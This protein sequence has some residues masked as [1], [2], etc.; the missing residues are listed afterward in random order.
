V[1]AIGIVAVAFVALL[2]LLPTGLGLFR[3]AMNSTVSSQ[4]AQRVLTD[5]QQTDFDIL[6][7]GIARDENTWD[8]FTFRA[9]TRA[10]PA[11]RYFDDQGTEVIPV[12]PA[13]LSATEKRRILYHVNTR[14]SVRA[15]RPKAAVRGATNSGQDAV[16]LALVTVEVAANPGNKTIPIRISP[17]AADDENEPLRNLFKPTPGVTI[18]TYSTMVARNQPFVAPATP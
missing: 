13:S 15:S 12:N 1:L 3:D 16:D 11:L 2:G 8:D 6:I 4:I 7:D 18:S 17:P 14:I 10:R 5:A 9:P